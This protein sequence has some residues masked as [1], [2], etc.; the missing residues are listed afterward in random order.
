[1]ASTEVPGAQ[2]GA[3]K[4]DQQATNTSTNPVLNLDEAQDISPI[5][6]PESAQSSE[7]EGED[8]PTGSEPKTA[9]RRLFGFGKKRKDDKGKRKDV[10]SNESN[11]PR[12]TPANLTFVPI[13]FTITNNPKSTFA[14]LQSCFTGRISNLRT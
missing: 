5:T 2:A 10:A 9:K 1:M 11:T 14:V 4:P 6:S 3:D 7:E 12:S 8:T 13:H